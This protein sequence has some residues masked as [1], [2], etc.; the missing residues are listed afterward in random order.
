MAKYSVIKKV[1]LPLS[2]WAVDQE[3]LLTIISPIFVGKEVKTNTTMEPAELC[4][5]VDLTTGE[6]VQVIIGAVLKGIFT[7]EYA[8]EK[9]VGK[10]FAITQHNAQGKKYKTYTVIEIDPES[11][12]LG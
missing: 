3:K 6:E 10:S 4:H 9:Y 2:K 8:G 11:V 5:A 12:E 1:T 7:D